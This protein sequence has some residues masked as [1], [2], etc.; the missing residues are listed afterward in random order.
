MMTG[1]A[2]RCRRYNI[3]CE[4]KDRERTAA[5]VANIRNYER[6]E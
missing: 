4:R 1:P 6:A 5:E 3:I 2:A